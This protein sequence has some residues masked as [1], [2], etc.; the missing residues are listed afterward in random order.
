MTRDCSSA[1]AR[2]ESRSHT[3]STGLRGCTSTLTVSGALRLVEEN[4]PPF[5]GR[6]RPRSIIY[7]MNPLAPRLASKGGGYERAASKWGGTAPRRPFLISRQGGDKSSRS[8]RCTRRHRSSA[9]LRMNWMNRSCHD[10]FSVA[11]YSLSA[12]VEVVRPPARTSQTFP[13][14]AASRRVFHANSNIARNARHRQHQ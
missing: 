11:T 5:Y 12:F 9:I 3:V 4:S 8:S 7:D 13:P 6:A 14:R 2:C 1:S 10:R